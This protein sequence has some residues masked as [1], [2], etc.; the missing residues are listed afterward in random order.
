MK[1]KEGV[2]CLLVDQ[3]NSKFKVSLVFEPVTEDE[4]LVPVFWNKI[5]VRRFIETHQI[6]SYRYFL[7][8]TPRLK[9]CTG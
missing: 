4:A 1:R 5:H 7:Q 6:S 3:V 2:N 8:Q 9:S